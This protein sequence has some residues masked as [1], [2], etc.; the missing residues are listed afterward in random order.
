MSGNNEFYSPLGSARFVVRWPGKVP[1]GTESDEL[2]SNVD[3]L[4]TLAAVLGEPLSEDEGP[5]S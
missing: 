1:A 5:D 3:M 2:W 4:A